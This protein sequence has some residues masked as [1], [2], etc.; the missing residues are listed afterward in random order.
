MEFGKRLRDVR[1]QNGLSQVELARMLG[2]HSVTLSRWERS[3]DY[4][5]ILVLM[6]IAN[7]FS[8][9]TDYLLGLSEMIHSPS[10]K[11]KRRWRLKKADLQNRTLIKNDRQKKGVIG[12]SVSLPSYCVSARITLEKLR[13]GLQR[14]LSILKKPRC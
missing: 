6:R 12:K 5:T 8:V 14:F 4:P 1:V 11:T 9:S 3:V 10:N 2:C 13:K 7:L